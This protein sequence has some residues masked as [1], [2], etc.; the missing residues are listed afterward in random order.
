[1]SI[2][3]ITGK[4]WAPGLIEDCISLLRSE[5]KAS[6][7]LFQRRLRLGYGRA[8]RLMDEL[9]DRGIV[10]P[11]KGAEPRDILVDLIDPIEVRAPRAREAVSKTEEA[12]CKA[13]THDLRETLI[14]VCETISLV[15]NA[16]RCKSEDA[17]DGDP[18]YREFF[19]ACASG[20]VTRVR[21]LLPAGIDV[22]YQPGP[23]TALHLAACN[24]HDAV[25]RLLI[26]KGANLE[27][28][29][30]AIGAPHGAYL[31][32]A[33]PLLLARANDRGPVVQTLLSHGADP[34][35]R[36]DS[37]LTAETLLRALREVTP[38]L[39]AI[40]LRLS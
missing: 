9:E 36:T 25:V 6:V 3:P 29:L 12:P 40:S 33:T 30:G 1:M 20:D 28:H 7:S 39:Q 10:G 23:A 16:I 22:S 4:E 17:D 13:S 5:Q 8:A 21:A 11:S 19:E 32:G 14:Q 27:P 2:D 26:E 31:T 18:P 38:G 37:G 34:K 15:E 24:G 35:V